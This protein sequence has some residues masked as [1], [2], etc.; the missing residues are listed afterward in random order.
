MSGCCTFHHWFEGPETQILRRA[1][2]ILGKSFSFP[3]LG[4]L[5][6]KWGRG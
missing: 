5:A 3:D 4:L 6:G 1:V 2:V